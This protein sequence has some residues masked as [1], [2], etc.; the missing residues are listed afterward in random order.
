MIRRLCI[1]MLGIGLATSALGWETRVDAEGPNRWQSLYQ[2]EPLTDRAGELLQPLDL[3]DE[4]TRLSDLAL[5]RLGVF[6]LFGRGGS[7]DIVVTDLNASFFRL[8]DLD[9]L[10]TVG[11]DPETVLEERRIPPPAHFSGVPDYSFTIYDWLN[12]NQLCPPGSEIGDTCHK[13]VFGWLGNL[14][15]THF[16]SQ[17]TGMYRHFHT[18]ALSYAARARMLHEAARE[19]GAKEAEVY[20]DI[21]REA[22]LEALAYEGYA[23]HFLQDRWAVGHMWERWNGPDYSAIPTQDNY[24]NTAVSGIAGI[25]HG[26]EAVLAEV[27]DIPAPTDYMRDFANYYGIDLTNFEGTFTLGDYALKADPMSSPILR[28]GHLWPMRWRH[29]STPEMSHLPGIGDDRLYD[30]QRGAFGAGHRYLDVFSGETVEL[31][32]LPLNADEQFE[33]MI[34]CSAAGWAEVIRALGEFDGTYGA[35]NAKLSPAAPNFDV[36][37]RDTCW[38]MW[39][40]NEA[41]HLGWSKNT[42]LSPK[43]MARL[44][45]AG[46]A[47]ADIVD[48]VSGDDAPKD[49]FGGD[50]LPR[51]PRKQLVQITARLELAN[52]LAPWGTEMAR[53]GIGAFGP[54]QPGNRYGLPDYAHPAAIENLPREDP[55]GRDTNTLFGAFSGAHS[56][57]WCRRLPEMIGAFRA[58]DDP[59]RTEICRYLGSFAYAGTEDAYD[60]VQ[61]ERLLFEGTEVKSLCHVRAMGLS[62]PAGDPYRLDQGYVSY[63]DGLNAMA[64]DGRTLR[65]V[66]N[67]CRAVPLLTLSALPELKNENL[68]AEIDAAQSELTLPGENLGNLPGDLLLTGP[69]GGEVVV[70]ISGWTPNNI[71]LDLSDADL[72]PGT[73]YRISLSRGDDGMESVGLFILRTE[74]EP[75]ELVRLEGVGPCRLRLDAEEYPVLDFVE[76]FGSWRG[77][78]AKRLDRYFPIALDFFTVAAGVM[79]READC[80]DALRAKNVAPHYDA[81]TQTLQRFPMDAYEQ[82]VFVE[83]DGREIKI[84]ERVGRSEYRNITLAW[85]AV[86]QLYQF[87]ATLLRN[88][89]DRFRAEIALLEEEIEKAQTRAERAVSTEADLAEMAEAWEHLMRVHRAAPAYMAY[90]AT[91]LNRW[92]VLEQK[93]IAQIMPRLEE[94]RVGRF[95]AIRANPSPQCAPMISLPAQTAAVDL[96]ASTP[97]FSQFD[98]Q[99]E[100]FDLEN[101]LKNQHPYSGLIWRYFDLP[102]RSWTT[103]ERLETL[104]G[105]R[106]YPQ[107]PEI[108]ANVEE[109]TVAG[110]PHYANAYRATIEMGSFDYLFEDQKDA[111]MGMGA[112]YEARYGASESTFLPENE[113][114]FT[115]L[116][117]ALIDRAIDDIEARM[118][119]RMSRADSGLLPW[120]TAEGIY[121]DATLPIQAMKVRLAELSN[122]TERCRRE[123]VPVKGAGDTP[124]PTLGV[125]SRDDAAVIEAAREAGAP[126]EVIEMLEALR[127]GDG[128]PEIEMPEIVVPEFEIPDPIMPEPLPVEPLGP[129]D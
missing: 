98:P 13:Y 97:V 21:I 79:E 48:Y 23:Q 27:R 108:L 68:V 85:G 75:I 104:V 35:W 90:I 71:T 64:E 53:G 114:E 110:C 55:T 58:S 12:K 36:L 8:E 30:A 119:I 5:K 2:L 22:E 103:P 127:E 65:T 96:A 99:G 50:G 38:D 95:R 47:L 84:G 15:S 10:P 20:R 122:Q 28:N 66:A 25:I 9:G 24:A 107:L 7:A 80:I 16:G 102:A 26:S 87:H 74:E 111:L 61:R 18:L 43:V 81:E 118:E 14:N 62:E 52:Q 69:D 19:V 45:W 70:R 41:M 109:T 121:T 106:M 83:P 101:P 77:L 34:A 117:C 72:R 56:D 73:D 57:H 4:H 67:W 126:E 37:A 46:N 42:I 32:D 78:R 116:R 40:T 51:L 93:L 49:F 112:L 44:A 124:V 82:I 33:H 59:R 6:G 17:A 54:F 100:A 63:P 31:D 125:G 86:D 1:A 113:E 129:V 88:M 94:M 92:A 60:G 115:C 91:G 120:G 3:K 29:A 76:R 39:A 128:L 123:C 89:A 11:D 105:W